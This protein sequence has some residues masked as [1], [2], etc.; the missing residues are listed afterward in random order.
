MTTSNQASSASPA[1]S[2][3]LASS[4]ASVQQP[5]ILHDFGAGRQFVIPTLSLNAYRAFR[6]RGRSLETVDVTTDEGLDLIFE[7]V[8]A[9]LVRNYPD[10]TV[11]AVSELLDFSN[12]TDVMTSVMDFGGNKRRSLAAAV[13]SA[14][15][16]NPVA[17]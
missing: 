7:A 14:S 5:G 3:P 6:Q 1:S 10:M 15:V 9:A 13:A 4:A 8:H 17:A 12:L 16:S 2:M 11:E